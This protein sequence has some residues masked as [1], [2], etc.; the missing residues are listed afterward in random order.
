MDFETVTGLV[1]DQFRG[2][3]RLIAP[4][5]Q[6]LELG[7]AWVRE[8]LDCPIGIRVRRSEAAGDRILVNGNSAAALG[9]GLRGGDGGRLVSITPLHLPGRRLL[10]PLR[11]ASR[12]PRDGGRGTSRSSRPR[13]SSPRSAW[14][15][16]PA[17]TDARGFTATS[18]PG[19]LAHDGV[20][21]AR[22]L[23]RGSRWC[24]ST[25]SGG[26]PRPACRPAPSR[27][28]S[29]RAR[30]HRTA[31]PSTCSSFRRTRPRRSSSRATAFDLAERVQTP[32]HRD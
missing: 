26:A 20:P 1:A 6:A 25:S 2:K 19:D 18:G 5:V 7:S 27:R 16:A 28:T 32:G 8:N 24:C 13:T 14:R 4:N 3:D 29:S 30:T 22:V 15:S 9:C 31:T 21:R 10:E 23:R 11:A 12:G 17:G